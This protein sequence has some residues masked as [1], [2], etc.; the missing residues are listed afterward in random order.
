MKQLASLSIITGFLLGGCTLL[1]PA[2]TN[3]ND[4]IEQAVNAEQQKQTDKTAAR[5]K[6]Q[7]LC[8]DTLLADGV[9]FDVGPCLS[10]SIA[11][12]WVCDVA[13]SPRQAVDDDPANQCASFR[14]GQVGHFVEVDGNCNVIQAR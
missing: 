10:N 9:N 11:P 8:Q 14:S 4:T 2:L 13:H 1:P 12:D 6:C 3:A 7:Q 5:V